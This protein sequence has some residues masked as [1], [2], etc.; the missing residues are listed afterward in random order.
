M[1]VDAEHLKRIS[2]KKAKE[3]AD[4]VASQQNTP[5]SVSS[6]I[7]DRVSSCA[8]SSTTPLAGYDYSHQGTNVYRSNCIAQQQQQQQQQ[9]QSQYTSNYVHVTQQMSACQVTRFA[10]LYSFLLR[11]LL[12]QL[13]MDLFEVAIGMHGGTVF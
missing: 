5:Q 7:S 12:F 3:E 10:C 1:E 9:H 2:S 13:V 4:R 8:S 6:F 11:Y